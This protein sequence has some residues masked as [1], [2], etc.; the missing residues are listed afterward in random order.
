MQLPPA[1]VGS[2]CRWSARRDVDPVARVRIPSIQSPPPTSSVGGV[3]TCGR[4]SS[5]IRTKG[6]RPPMADD[7]KSKLAEKFVRRKESDK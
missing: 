4:A 3:L 1:P 7:K 5:I 6:W 2:E